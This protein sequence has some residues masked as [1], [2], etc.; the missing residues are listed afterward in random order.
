[1]R[2][3]KHNEEVFRTAN[4]KMKMINKIRTSEH[5]PSERKV[6]GSSNNRKD[7]G[8]TYI[9]QKKICEDSVEGAQ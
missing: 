1:M 5:I 6:R 2:Q 7:W 3:K 9:K 4:Y 8:D